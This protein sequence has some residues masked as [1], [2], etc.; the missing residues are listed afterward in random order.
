MNRWTTVINGKEINIDCNNCKYLN[1][2]EKEQSKDKEHHKC[3]K[4]NIRIFHNIVSEYRG[5]PKQR[6]Y[7]CLKCTED[8]YI[9]Y[10]E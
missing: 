5:N 9:N 6:L 3:L 10:I 7:P 4:Y 8:K 2:T 1:I